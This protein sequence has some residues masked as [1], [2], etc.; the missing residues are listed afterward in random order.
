M[1][2]SFSFLCIAFA[3][4]SAL[5]RRIGYK[6]TLEK[7]LPSQLGSINKDRFPVFHQCNSNPRVTL[8]RFKIILHYGF[9]TTQ[10]SAFA[11]YRGCY[12]KSSRRNPSNS[13]L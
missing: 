8:S 5:L 13:E 6:Y 7:G 10:T 9:S 2:S 1:M 4:L 3:L 11:K 12:A